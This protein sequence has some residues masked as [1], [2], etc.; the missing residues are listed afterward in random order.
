MRE[1]PSRRTPAGAPAL[2]KIDL[3]IAR[4]RLLLA[5]VSARERALEDQRRTFREQHNKLITFS[6]YGDSTLDSVL[7]MLGDVQERLSHLDGTSQSLAAIRKRAEIELESLQLTKG[8]EEAKI[9]LQA[10]RAKQ[11]GPF[12]PAD[13]LTPAEI[14]AEIARLQSLINEASERAAK[15]IEKSTRR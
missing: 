2:K 4:L 8:I 7:A 14:Q 9:L 11:A 15:T 10:L 13:A 6:M 3:T 1:E 12:D 5:D